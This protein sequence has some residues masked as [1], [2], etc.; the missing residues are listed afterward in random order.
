MGD[1]MNMSFKQNNT[2]N[3]CPIQPV[4]LKYIFFQSCENTAFSVLGIYKK[5]HFLVPLPCSFHIL[6]FK[7]QFCEKILPKSSTIQ[8]NVCI[9]KHHMNRFTQKIY[10]KQH[11][12]LEPLKIQKFFSV[13]IIA[14]PKSKENNASPLK[15]K[16]T[17]F[18]CNC[19]LLH[20]MLKNI[21]CLSKNKHDSNV[22]DLNSIATVQIQA[23]NSES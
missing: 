14:S 22:D 19:Y 9:S 4:P 12:S 8:I 6:K 5:Y 20:F 23:R 13:Y 10:F 17:I 2:C 16:S 1:N 3:T 11:T 15:K 7:Y 21:T 18:G